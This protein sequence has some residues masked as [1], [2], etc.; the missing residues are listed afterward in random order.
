VPPSDHSSWRHPSIPVK[1]FIAI[2]VLLYNEEASAT[3]ILTKHTHM[4]TERERERETY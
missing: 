4:H 1:G 2:P 3:F